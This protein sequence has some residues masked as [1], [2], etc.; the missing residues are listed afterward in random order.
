[1]DEV[2]DSPGSE[3]RDPAEPN[4]AAT[5]SEPRRPD[6]A[7]PTQ[8]VADEAWAWT[9]ETEAEVV[10][11]IS[12]LHVTAVL[13]THNAGAWLPQTLTS[14]RALDRRPDRLIAVDTG[15]EDNSLS[16]LKESGLFE[17]GVAGSRSDGF[18]EAVGKALAARPSG[19]EDEWLWLLHDDITVAPDALRRLL[20]CA[21]RNPDA[22]VLG[23]KLLQPGRGDGPRRLSELGVSI[24]D[25]ARRHLDL[26]PGEIDQKQHRSRD[27]LGVSTCGMLVR[28]R[29][30]EAVGGLAAELPVFR[31]GVEF[32]WRATDAGYRV[33]TCPEAMITH[34]QA[35][36]SG[37]RRSLLVGQDV[38]ATDR[39]LGMRAVAAHRGPLVSLRL[40]WGSLLRAL[41]FLLAKAPD[42][43]RSELRALGAFFDGGSVR[44]LRAR[45]PKP[46]SAEA[47]ARVKELRPRW[48]SSF[49]VAGDAIVG[50]FGERWQR[51]FAHDADTS[52]DELTGD[53][54]AATTD[55]PQRSLL[56][57]P[58]LLTLV[59]ASVL[60][61]VAG[62]NLIRPGVL[63]SDVLL[64]ARSTLGAAYQA[65]L[66]PIIGAPG[67]APPP[68]L[69][70]TAL[71]STLTLGRPDWF[72]SLV[73]LA[74][75][76]LAILIAIPLLRRV[77]PD[78]RVRLAAAVLYALL[79]VLLGAV[80]RGLLEV[81]VLAILLPPLGVSVRALVLRRTRG[82]ES[83]RSAWATG[84]LLAIILA[85][86]P[87]LGALVAVA[88]IVGVVVFRRDRGRL[89]RL[90][91]AVGLPALL[92][93]PWLPTL[94]NGWSR[95]LV[96]PDAGLRGLETGPVWALMLGR[97]PGPGLPP[98]WLGAAVLGVVWLLALLGAVIRPTSPALLGAWGTALGAFALAA[99]FQGRLATVLPQGT[100]VRPDTELLLFVG[101]AALVLAAAV[102]FGRIAEALSRRGF[103]VAHLGTIAVGLLTVAALLASVAWWGIGGATGPLKRTE[104]AELPPFLRN[105]MTSDA[106]MRTLAIEYQG[107]DPHWSLIADDQERLGDADRGLA[108]GGSG[109][110]QQRTSSL[111]AR[112]LSGAGDE[113]VAE[114]LASLAVS[115][116]WVRGATEEHR[117]RIN[118][119]PGLGAEAVFGDT[120]VW[121][122]PATAGRYV[123]VGGP[124]P[125]VVPSTPNGHGALDLAASGQPRQLIIHEPTDRR[126][127]VEFQGNELPVTT[128]ADRTLVNLPPQAGRLEVD[129]RAPL[130][131]WL[132]LAQLL[133]ALVAV[134]L[135][136]PSLA[137]DRQRRED[138]QGARAAA[139]EG[140]RRRAAAAAGRRSA[141]PAEADEAAQPGQ[142]EDAETR[143][144]PRMD[145][146]ER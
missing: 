133:L 103:G 5:R 7:R 116:I 40:I 145:G 106:R 64:P 66:A 93:A 91:I 90:G 124:E 135:A 67:I 28:R 131:P 56:A 76:P 107:A 89:G 100:R 17:V 140:G 63:S 58:L 94:L 55:R 128:A 25:T 74:G 2:H 41:G 130:H 52:I 87:I 139:V 105:A 114:D 92:L 142:T 125:L 15:S 1:M 53:E 60:A 32:G 6:R 97:T 31:D 83:W 19:P 50:V 42:R 43:S 24:S 122:V 48:W 143:V 84:L 108:F 21:V 96:G 120:V 101:F 34:R 9:K 57:N 119:T 112:M 132:A 127:R 102:G 117:A 35:G 111:V 69:G 36:R 88:A 11:D 85:Y 144:L 73:L 137:G 71:G 86:A 129:Y 10:P 49:A 65:Y 44:S 68:W 14:L 80:N 45:V 134:V 98:L 109:T 33:R 136:A 77:I 81:A 59:V 82:P 3:H 51:S 39:L 37:L 47:R 23:P 75:V 95:L 18:G 99:V 29:V 110:M 146:G 38:A 138:Q 113:R 70:W 20:E 62:R 72:V 8:I 54:F 22:D 115:H 12:H 79:P 123:V 126:L 141:G 13:V 61:F 78:L 27:T 26:E 16:L 121:T 46:A 104:V 4:D 118:N 30:Y